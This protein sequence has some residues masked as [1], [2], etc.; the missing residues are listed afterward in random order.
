MRNVRDSWFSWRSL[1]SFTRTNVVCRVWGKALQNTCICLA[2]IKSFGTWTGASQQSEGMIQ[3]ASLPRFQTRRVLNTVGNVGKSPN[4]SNKHFLWIVEKTFSY[5][6]IKI[7]NANWF[8]LTF[9]CK[10]QPLSI[11]C[12]FQRIL[13]RTFIKVP[14]TFSDHCIFHSGQEMPNYS[15]Y[16]FVSA[17]K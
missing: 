6:I 10:W 3:R 16:V 9:H 13:E 11:I 8:I 2:F 5:F 1:Q 12:I 4:K 17:E 15:L 7:L 14:D